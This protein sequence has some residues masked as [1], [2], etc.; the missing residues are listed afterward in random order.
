MPGTRPHSDR[1]PKR[2]QLVLLLS[3]D[4]VAA[5]LLA[6]LVETLGYDVHFARP[7]ESA[8]DSLRR[9]R[10]QI[11]LV[12]C[13]DPLACRSDFLGRAKM[14]GVSV[15]VFGTPET[16][17]RVREVAVA[18]NIDTLLMPPELN[19]LEAALQRAGTD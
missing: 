14:R 5:A 11:C 8:D 7:P 3:H 13:T 18:H 9:V 17:A 12:D 15:V 6:A 1:L 16:L 19:V 4:A 2:D 10:P